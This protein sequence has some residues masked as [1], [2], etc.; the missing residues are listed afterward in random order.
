LYAGLAGYRH[1]IV[2]DNKRHGFANEVD[3][4]TARRQLEDL[5]AQLTFAD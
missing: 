1:T 2:H 4:K 5:R 3:W